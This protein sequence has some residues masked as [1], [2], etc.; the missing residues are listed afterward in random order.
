MTPYSEEDKFADPADEDEEK[1]TQSQ[2][3]HRW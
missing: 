3:Q 2:Q 1:S